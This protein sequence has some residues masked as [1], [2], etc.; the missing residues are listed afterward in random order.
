MININM[1]E[2]GEDVLIKAKVTDILVEHGEIKYKIKAEHSNNDLDHNFTEHQ[3][4]ALT[5]D[6]EEPDLVEDCS[7]EVKSE[8]DM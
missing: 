5:K 2:V 4:I 6:E 7:N 1:F 3:L 8:K